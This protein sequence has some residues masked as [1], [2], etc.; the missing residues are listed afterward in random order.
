M[1]LILLYQLL[2]IDN[3]LSKLATKSDLI[4][5]YLNL[6]FI[7]ILIAI[8]YFEEQNKKKLY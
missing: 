6:N 7:S 5:Y 3:L 8:L 4:L 2:L 1:Q